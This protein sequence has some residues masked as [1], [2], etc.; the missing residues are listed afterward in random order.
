MN[1][2]QFKP[3]NKP[4]I[5]GSDQRSAVE[6]L[7]EL[8][9]LRDEFESTVSHEL[10]TPLTS[11]RAFAEILLSEPDLEPE[12]RRNFLQIVVNETKRLTRLTNDV[13]DPPRNASGR[14]D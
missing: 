8:E 11:I 9:R 13:L 5:A 10:R 4:E 7:H 6:R 3:L 1:S 12:Q 2:I 14:V